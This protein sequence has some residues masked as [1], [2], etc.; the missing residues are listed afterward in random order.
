MIKISTDFHSMIFHIP[1]SQTFNV[2]MHIIIMSLIHTYIRIPLSFT[3]TNYNT[4]T[5]SEMPSFISKANL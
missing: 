5:D 1:Q 4:S 3:K 2:H